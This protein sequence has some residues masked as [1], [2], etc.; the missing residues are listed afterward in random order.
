[1]FIIFPEGQST[2]LTY[3]YTHTLIVHRKESRNGALIIYYLLQSSPVVVVETPAY[4]ICRSPENVQMNINTA[5]FFGD[6]DNES[7][8]Q[9]V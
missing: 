1:M 8:E 2:I 7:Y 3:D 5:L 9:E 4:S 6:G